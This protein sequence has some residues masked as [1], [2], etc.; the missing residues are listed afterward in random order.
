MPPFMHEDFSSLSL[1]RRGVH[2]CAL[3]FIRAGIFA[4]AGTFQVF[5]VRKAPSIFPEAHQFLAVLSGTLYFAAN[6]FTEIKSISA[7]NIDNSFV[8]IIILADNGNIRIS[9]R[10][11]LSIAHPLQ[12]DI[13]REFSISNPGID[14]R[15][16]IHFYTTNSNQMQNLCCQVFSMTTD[17]QLKRLHCCKKRKAKKSLAEVDQQ[18]EILNESST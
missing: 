2:F 16:L 5:P 1:E 18:R 11:F 7:R 14:F 6:S 4:S 12:T 17:T 3:A 15:K 10:Y 8:N 9:F 13:I